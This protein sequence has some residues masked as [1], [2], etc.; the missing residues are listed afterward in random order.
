MTTTS[1]ISNTTPSQFSIAHWETIKQIHRTLCEEILAERYKLALGARELLAKFVGISTRSAG[2]AI[3]LCKT[4]EEKVI[5]SQLGR[6]KKEISRQEYNLNGYSYS[7][8]TVQRH[9]TK[10]NFKFGKGN[11]LNILHDSP[12]NIQLRKTYL[13]KRIGNLN[14]N[15]MP[16]TPEVFLDE[17]YMHLDHHSKQTWF[18]PGMDMRESGRKPMLVIFGA[19]IAFRQDNRVIFE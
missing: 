1:P 9:L 3:Q 2:K 18:E 14:A 17:S 6:P 11:K 5:A 15:N 10:I 19:F 13:D 16:I 12:A 7:K 8:R 4:D